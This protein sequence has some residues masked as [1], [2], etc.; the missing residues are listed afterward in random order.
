MQSEAG[1]VSPDETVAANLGAEYGVHQVA[2]RPGDPW[3]SDP[4]PDDAA[5]GGSISAR[6]Q[7]AWGNSPP[8]PQ[9]QQPTAPAAAPP[10]DS[11]DAYP[12][13]LDDASPVASSSRAA[14]DDAGG[15]AWDRIRRQGQH[16]Q[17][18]QDGQPWPGPQAAGGQ[19][20]GNDGASSPSRGPRDGYTFSSSD[21]EKALAKGQAQKEFDELL[22]RERSGV[23][24]E[25][26]RW[27]RK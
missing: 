13:D 6:A 27:N 14:R 2:G 25:R 4:P 3:G 17:P 21:E 8:R 12:D 9:P 7:P 15:S 5:Q 16:P 22:E 11:W 24:Q 18:G 20:G 23:D 19:W 10:R 1:K 26:D